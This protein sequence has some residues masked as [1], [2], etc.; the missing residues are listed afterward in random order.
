[1]TLRN[2]GRP[3]RIVCAA[4]RADDGELLIGIRHYSPDMLRQMKQRLDGAKW[5]HR[6]DDD[7]G[8]VDQWGQWLSRQ[9]AHALASANGQL[10][11]Q[12]NGP[13]DQK[14]YSEGLY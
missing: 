6:G 1:M 11:Y 3:R 8:F 13:N 2:A 4:L 5:K 7:Q 12:D 9:E 10:I 14:L